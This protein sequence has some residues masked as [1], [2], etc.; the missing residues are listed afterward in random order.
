[1]R[2]GRSA[3]SHQLCLRLQRVYRAELRRSQYEVDLTI[4]YS[5]TTLVA[6]IYFYY[7]V[8]FSDRALLA[9]RGKRDARSVAQVTVRTPKPRA[10]RISRGSDFGEHT[11]RSARR[12]HTRASP[13]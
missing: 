7:V 5:R 13:I 2:G 9:V 12:L 3:A 1:M 10:E 6:T 11:Q 8:R 4:V